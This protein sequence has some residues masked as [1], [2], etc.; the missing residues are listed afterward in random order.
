V[1]LA[2]LYPALRFLDLAELKFEQ[3]AVMV[4]RPQVHE[5]HT[6]MQWSY[7]IT[8]MPLEYIH[9]IF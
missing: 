6:L 9:Y 4:S 1:P 3:K 8:L 7:S 2:L 5:Q